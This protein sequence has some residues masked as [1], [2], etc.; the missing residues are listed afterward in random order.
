MQV[1]NLK[2]PIQMAAIFS[3]DIIDLNTRG[4]YGGLPPLITYDRH[5]TDITFA[6]KIILNTFIWLIDAF[7]PL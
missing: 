1:M 6:I 5:N 7:Q 4:N 2:G 3:D